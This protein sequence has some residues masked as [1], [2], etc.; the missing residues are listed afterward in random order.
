MSFMKLSYR[1]A[2]NQRLSYLTGFV[3][4]AILYLILLSFNDWN[5]VAIVTGIAFQGLSVTTGMFMRFLSGLGIT[6]TYTT[7]CIFIFRI[8]SP[9]LKRKKSRMRIVKAIVFIPAMIILIYSVYTIGGA[10]LFSRTPSYFDLLSMLFGVWTLVIMVHIIPIIKGE[11]TPEVD[12]TTKD[13]LQEKMGNWRFSIWRGYQSKI[14]QDYGRVAEGE[15]ERY[16]NRLSEIRTLLSGLLLLPISLILVIITPLAFLSVILW[17]RIFSLHR[18]SFSLYE[19]LLL[20]LITASVAA[21][22]TLSLTQLNLAS[23]NLVFSVSYGLGLFGG[24]IL[25]FLIILRR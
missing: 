15:F 20:V 22:T 12:K 5:P 7:V 19:R 21:L 9:A 8:L 23:Y 13:G 16:G 17:I 24:L 3:I 4:G 2:K 25:F 14:K 11:Y 10:V 1:I 18:K 6:L